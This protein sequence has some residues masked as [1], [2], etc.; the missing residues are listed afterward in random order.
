MFVIRLVGLALPR[1][2]SQGP[3]VKVQTHYKTHV[4][5]MTSSLVLLP[6][7]SWSTNTNLLNPRTASGLLLEKLDGINESHHHH[8]YYQNYNPD[9]TGFNPPNINSDFVGFSQNHTNLTNVKGTFSCCQQ[10]P[11]IS[12]GMNNAGTITSSYTIS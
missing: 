5:P 6:L 9:F 2:C 4:F 3:L 8:H 7:T 11:T 1:C 12:G 10:S